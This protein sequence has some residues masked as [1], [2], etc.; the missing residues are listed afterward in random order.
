ME[1]PASLPTPV[2]GMVEDSLL[3]GGTRVFLQS[4][5]PGAVREA[6]QVLEEFFSR[7]QEPPPQVVSTYMAMKW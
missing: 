5:H 3:V 4:Q 6:R 1:I 7:Q 2:Q